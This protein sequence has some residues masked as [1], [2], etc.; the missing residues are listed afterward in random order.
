MRGSL[1]EELAKYDFAL[2]I[3]ERLTDY[4]K[5]NGNFSG[6]TIG[7][8][9]H[10][11]EITA[12]AAEVILAAG[13]RLFISECNPETTNIP[14]VEHMRIKGAEVFLGPES[15]S[16]V[17]N[18]KP[19]VISD[20]GLVLIRAYEVT[21]GDE[22][23][24]FGASEITTSGITAL[25]EL[26]EISIPVVDINGGQLKTY[27]ENFHGVGDGIADLLSHL[28]GRIW[29]GRPVSVIGYGNVG[30]GVSHYLR[31]LG[32][33][34]HIVE[35]NPIRRLVAHYDGYAVQTLNEALSHADLIITATG[36]PGVIG[37]T[38]WKLARDGATFVNVGHWATEM[39]MEALRT[40]STS[41]DQ[42]IPYLR[43]Y[44]LPFGKRIYVLAEGHPANVV[45]LSGSPEPTLIHLATEILCMNY[46]LGLRKDGVSMLPGAQPLPREV[47]TKAAELAL[48]ALNLSN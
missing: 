22:S 18:A 41:S 4:L 21:R 39:D 34:V 33:D 48:Q 42:Q 23:F 30:S 10:L 14:S 47:E 38:E 7:W 1:H 29:S 36:Q 45:V 13:A 43:E 9:C 6:H 35:A 46:L 25:S 28:T 20:T 2:P 27:I 32:A 16:A 40:L 24:V 15:C 5:N 12:A 19:H 44:T 31:R 37:E 3:M 11:T 8:H 26:P 17:L